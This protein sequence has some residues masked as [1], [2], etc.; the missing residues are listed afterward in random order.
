MGRPPAV[1]NAQIRAG[2]R[3]HRSA[4]GWRQESCQS[5][6]TL[7]CQGAWIKAKVEKI[8]LQGGE[9]TVN[10]DAI[11]KIDM[12]AMSMTFPIADR[13]H[14]SKMKAGDTL[15]FQAANQGGVVRIVNV[16]MNH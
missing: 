14:L 3:S 11:P 1:P 4:L 5:A 10:H 13:G 7:P 2:K 8:D 12:P 16:R 6:R 9:V 15:E